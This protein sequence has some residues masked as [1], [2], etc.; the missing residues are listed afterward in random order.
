MVKLLSVDTRAQ[1]GCRCS[2][3]RPGPTSVGC[4]LGRGRRPPLRQGQTQAVRYARPAGPSAASPA[5]RHE[6]PVVARARD[7]VTDGMWATPA[8]RADHRTS[9]KPGGPAIPPLMFAAHRRTRCQLS[10]CGRGHRADRPGDLAGAEHTR[11][12]RTYTFR[13]ARTVRSN[14]ITSVSRGWSGRSLFMS[15]LLLY[16]R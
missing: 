2:P 1:T 3:R 14:R 12:R 9:Y 16:T 5:G 8:D 10:L 6:C 11:S 15:A 13:R 4:P 7:A